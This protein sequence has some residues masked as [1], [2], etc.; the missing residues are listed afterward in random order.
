MFTTK[1][2]VRKEFNTLQGETL[3]FYHI[4]MQKAKFCHF[5]G[6]TLK[7]TP[8]YGAQKSILPFL[9]NTLLFYQNMVHKP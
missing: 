5:Q 2:D 8:K 6:E 7:F 1:Y 3:M 4:I 9:G